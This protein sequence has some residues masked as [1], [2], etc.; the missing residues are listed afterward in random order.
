MR[1]LLML[2][3][4]CGL[5]LFAANGYAAVLAYDG[6]GDG[7][8]GQDI[9][10]YSGTTAESGLS[11]TWVLVDG[12]TKVID[13]LTDTQLGIEGGYTPETTGGS[14]HLVYTA[15]WTAGVQTRPLASAV[16]LSVDGTYY[17]SFFAQ[18]DGS[19]DFIAQL[20]LYDGTNAILAGQA[21]NRGLNA[22][23]GSITTEADSGNDQVDTH[24]SN[25]EDGFYLITLVKTNSATTNDLAVTIDWWHLSTSGI[26]FHGPEVTRTQ[27]FSGVTSVFSQLAFKI[28]GWVWMDELRLADSM[29]AATGGVGEYLPIADTLSGIL[30]SDELPVENGNF[31]EPGYETEGVIDIPGWAGWEPV[32]GWSGYAGT[33]DDDDADG[34]GWNLGTKGV[35]GAVYGITSTQMVEGQSYT[36][37]A[38]NRVR[39]SATGVDVSVIAGPYIGSDPNIP[40]GSGMGDPNVALVTESYAIDHDDSW[41]PVSVTYVA[42][43]ADAGRFIGVKFE[44]KGTLS[45]AWFRYD[46]VHLYT[47]YVEIKGPKDPSPANGVTDISA[48]PMTLSWTPCNDPN[49]T[50]QELYYYVGDAQTFPD[51]AAYKAVTKVTTVSLSADAMSYGIGSLDRDEYVLWRVDTVFDANSCTGQSWYFQTETEDLPPFVDAGNSYITWLDKLPQSVAGTVDDSG[52][53][54]IIS[55]DVDW[56]IVSAPEDADISFDKNVSDPLNPTVD[57][58]TDIA[59]NYV[60]QLTATD[61]SDG[62]Q[63]SQTDSDT[64]TIRVA[65]DACAAKQLDSAGYNAYDNLGNRNCVVD[66]PDFAAMAAVWMEDISLAAPVAYEE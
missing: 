42:T 63:G 7:V 48:G 15:S 14:E 43:A 27:T 3:L 23:Y 26:I 50:G 39:W 33:R 60:I 12:G 13:V 2:L 46:D 11:G 52:E 22:T 4:I 37:T 56:V 25:G 57:F 17:L 21:Y 29:L 32:D 18:S 24:Y 58:S 35:D 16:D 55:A 44:G 1:S 5:A 59:G 36:F 51:I 38:Q 53:N 47:D 45:N 66:L 64:I 34:D 65:E 19:D 6:F 10:G 30:Y 40:F 49:T 54:D 31:I 20:G 61:K 28:S 41:Q 62:S 9:N 8:D